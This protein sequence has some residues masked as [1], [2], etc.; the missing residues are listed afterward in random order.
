MG[1]KSDNCRLDGKVVVVTGAGQGIGRA[2]ALALAQAGAAVVVNDM[3]K[4]A[5]HAVAHSIRA[6]GGQAVAVMAAIGTDGAAETCVSAAADHFGRLDG[7]FAN[8]GVLR[9][10]VLWKTE[11]DAF[12]LV[13]ATHLRGTFQCA[14]AA[15]RQFRAQGGGGSLIYAASP[16]GQSGNFGQGAYAAAKAGIV[17]M[18]RSHAL[19]LA[20]DKVTVNAIIPTALTRMTA[21]IPALAPHVAALERGEPLPDNLR[22]RHGIGTAQDIAPLVVFLASD[23]ARGIT[24]QCIG[25]GGDRLSLWTHPAEL[26]I[27]TQSGGWTTEALTAQW[28]DF[29]DGAIQPLGVPLAFD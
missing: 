8:A 7:L 15:V 27:A 11:D 13:I 9:D 17:G 2:T 3:D 10:S 14:R 20:R 5:A 6:D 22:A 12:D 19:E 28:P 26:R 16:A 24:G 1:G 25:I 21:T 23:R 4:D 29:S 18:M